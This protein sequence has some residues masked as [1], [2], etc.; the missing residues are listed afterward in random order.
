MGAR[1]SGIFPKYA[2]WVDAANIIPEDGTVHELK[3]LEH[4]EE[5]H[6]LTYVTTAGDAGDQPQAPAIKL[7]A[8]DADGNNE[9]EILT[10][11]TTSVGKKVQ[12]RSGYELQGV[13]TGYVKLVAEPAAGTAIAPRAQVS[14]F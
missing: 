5:I 1:S 12:V 13:A 10:I 9:V 4:S 7:V 8:C 6:V 2:S 3:F 14:L 11:D